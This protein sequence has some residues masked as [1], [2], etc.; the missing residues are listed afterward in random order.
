MK[1]PLSIPNHDCGDQT[2]QHTDETFHKMAT[3]S[4]ALDKHMTLVLCNC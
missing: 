4:L 3:S 1:G 2:L